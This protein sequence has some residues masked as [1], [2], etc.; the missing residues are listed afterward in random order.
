MKK[1]SLYKHEP[2]IAYPQASE[3]PKQYGG[4]LG[5]PCCQGASR[6][7]SGQHLLRQLQLGRET[8]L[9]GDANPRAARPVI[10]PRL[11]QIELLASRAWPCRLA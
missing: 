6:E 9:V 3:I 10:D 2:F 11:G 8:S 5:D 1:A 7:G 4:A